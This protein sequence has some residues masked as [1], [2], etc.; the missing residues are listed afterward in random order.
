[1][2]HEAYLM[3]LHGTCHEVLREAVYNLSHEKFVPYAASNT[4]D[5]FTR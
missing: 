5:Y 4:L 3:K 2:T 1:M